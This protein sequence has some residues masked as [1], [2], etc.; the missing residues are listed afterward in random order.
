MHSVTFG[1]N[2]CIFTNILQY[3]YGKTKST[4]AHKG[5]F[6]SK[7]G[8]FLMIFLATWLSMADPL[9][10][11]IN[12]D[13]GSVCTSIPDGSALG[14]KPKDGAF[15][16]VP[17]NNDKYCHDQPMMDL[18]DPDGSLSAWGWAITIVCTWSGFLFLFIG[19][20]WIINF[21]RKVAAQW[22]ALRGGRRRQV[23][24]EQPLLQ[25]VV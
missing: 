21:P 18:E 16:P 5:S 10:H 22:Q 13:W 11:L 9:R 1:L 4:R 12:D 8:P 17:A 3:V 15:A 24:A 19:I 20:F 2:L 14:L 25:A 7:W 23:A 6:F